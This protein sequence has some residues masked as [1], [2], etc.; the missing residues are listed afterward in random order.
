MVIFRYYHRKLFV[1]I[2]LYHP[3]YAIE[4]FSVKEP[5]FFF[6]APAVE[7]VVEC[8]WTALE[9]PQSLVQVIFLIMMRECPREVLIDLNLRENGLK[10]LFG[11][12]NPP[13]P[14]QVIKRVRQIILDDPG[15]DLEPF[16]D[17]LWEAWMWLERARRVRFFQHLRRQR[18]IREA[19]R[20]P[21]A[22]R[23]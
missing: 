4:F 20:R 1:A 9:P 13:P 23:P 11:L 7:K 16:Q 15:L 19:R 6:F 17:A 21:R 22:P 10:D 3:A 12:P 14:E 2:D 5:L 18:R 8:Q